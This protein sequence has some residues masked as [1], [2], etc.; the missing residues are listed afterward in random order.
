MKAQ[1]LA[2][3]QLRG[4]TRR[5]WTWLER[6]Y[7]ARRRWCVMCQERPAMVEGSDFCG[8]VCESTYAALSPPLDQP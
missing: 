6:Q 4:L 5:A 3:G 1:L 7:D 8:E 2:V